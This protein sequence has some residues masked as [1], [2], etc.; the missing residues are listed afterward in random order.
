MNVLKSSAIYSFF[1]FL[2]RIFGFLRD[3]LIANFLGTGF[4]A[5]I[6]FVAFRFPNT[7]RRI[8]SEGALNSAFVPIYS[9]LLLGT[10]K[11]ESGKF[12]G[13][14]ISILALSTLLIV[15]LVEIF[16]PYF[17]HLIAPGFI[18]DEEKFSQLI[19]TSRIIFPF[20]I[21]IS[22]SSIYSSIL[23]AN[24]K[25]ALSA[26]LPIILNVIL[27]ISLILAYYFSNAFLEFLSWGVLFAGIIQVIFLFFSIKS[28]KIIIHF[29]RKLSN[30]V[31]S[32][33]K[34]FFPSFFSSGL[35]QIN[36]LIGT[37]IASYES[38]AVSYLYYADR[39]YQLPLALVGIALGIALLPSISK[40]I[41]EDS[42][43]EVKVT[44]EKTIKFALMFSLPAAVGLY[45]IPEIIIQVLFERGEF[46]NFATNETSMALKMFSLGLVA[47]VAVKILTP[48]FFAYENAK[49]PLLIS[50]FNLI[51][52]T[53]LSIILFYHI[54][55]IG[56]AL[57]TSISAWL[58]V[59]VLYVFL[60][61]K[62]YFSL[63]RDIVY[64]I[65]VIIVAS[66]VLGVYLFWVNHYYS[67]YFQD[68][69]IYQLL[70]I[71]LILL[72]SIVLYFFLI[73]FYKPF[74]YNEVRK[75]FLSND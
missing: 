43:S 40:K 10:E 74:S 24:G 31:K 22:I 12:A 53:T 48:V 16:M 39:I 71:S 63:S 73:S 70:G 17:L 45:F 35:L 41:K 8:F 18:A 9:K 2:S 37:I 75:S 23:N 66:A 33:F 14:I 3:I 34:L 30:S 15:I 38:G 62:K 47:F 57:A 26:A 46:N 44:I 69:L 19:D 36:I 58:N 54:G 60:T 5:D 65:F 28:N 6:F 25:F 13:N 7:F 27:C 4:L 51:I 59:F 61:R 52:N 32:F 29:T 11:F 64:P 42:H 67:F 72:S 21:L 50:L 20:L 55:F 68:L 1:T 56:I 49:L